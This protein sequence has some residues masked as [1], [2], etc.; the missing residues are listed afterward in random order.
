MKTYEERQCTLIELDD[1]RVIG[2]D[3]S[4]VILYPSLEAF[5]DGNEGIDLAVL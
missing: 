3:N 1:G 4:Q 5:Y 2:I